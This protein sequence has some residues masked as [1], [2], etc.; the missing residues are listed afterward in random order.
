MDSRD[1]QERQTDERKVM[2]EKHIQSLDGRKLPR[3]IEAGLTALNYT[4]TRVPMNT[5]KVIRYL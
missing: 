1:E 2:P 5:V 3:K 4:A